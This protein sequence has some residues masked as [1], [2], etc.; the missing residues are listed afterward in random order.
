MLANSLVLRGT[1]SLVPNI[2]GGID[3]SSI[4]NFFYENGTWFWFLIGGGS[5][6][7][8]FIIKLG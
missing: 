6:F 5:S 8:S 7:S 1:P 2:F 3:F 4:S